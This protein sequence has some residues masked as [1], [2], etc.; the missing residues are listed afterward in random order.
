MARSL[1]SLVL[2]LTIS[3]AMIGIATSAPAK[4]KREERDLE[5]TTDSFLNVLRLLTD[6][7]ALAMALDQLSEVDNQGGT[8]WNYPLRI[9]ELTPNEKAKRRH[10]KVSEPGTG[11]VLNHPLS[12]VD[13]ET[14]RALIDQMLSEVD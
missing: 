11:P 3:C 1:V 6:K 7:K 13:S 14:V 5:A 9:A 4:E 8:A 12:G 2:T 10:F